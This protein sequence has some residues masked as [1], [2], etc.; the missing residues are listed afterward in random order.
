MTRAGVD[1]KTGDGDLSRDGSLPTDGAGTTRTGW[2]AEQAQ[3]WVALLIIDLV[4][5]STYLAMAV[6][7]EGIPPFAMAATRYLVAALAFATW[8]GRRALVHAAGSR[9][10]WRDAVVIGSL[11]AAVGNGFVAWGQQQVPSGWAALVVSLAPAWTAL[12]AWGLFGERLRPRTALGIVLGIV[13]VAWLFL[14]RS[15]ADLGDL[16]HIAAIAVA[17]VGWALGSLYAQRLAVPAATTRAGMALQLL[18]GGA[19]LASLS[20]AT[21]E[22][23]VTLDRVPMRSVMALGYLIVLGTIVAWSAYVWLLRHAPIEHVMTYA[24][25]NPL[26]A[27]GLGIVVRGEPF[28]PSVIAASIV[29]LAAVGLVVRTPAVRPIPANASSE[30]APRS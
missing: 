25:V 10:A 17:P 2:R 16:A 23:V 15:A 13:G 18:G 30:D 3:R 19:V 7:M 12:L 4:W 24:F 11:M 9:R 5:G 28:G 21:A 26:V 14:P 29:I 6:A 1:V 22:P 8:A 27:L 20:L